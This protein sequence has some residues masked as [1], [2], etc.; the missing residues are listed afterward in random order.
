MIYILDAYNVIHKIPSLDAALDKDLRTARAALIEL[1]G[2]WALSRGEVFKI[3]LVFDG[4]SEFR[5]LPQ[6]SPPK[7]QLVFSETGEDAD[8]R[9][10]DIL[11]ELGEKTTKCVV[12]DDNFVRNQARAYKTQVISVSEFNQWIHK[13]GKNKINPASSS[14]SSK[15]FSLSRKA[16]DEITQAYKKHLGL[17]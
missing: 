2:R 14:S 5:D 11:E 3:I 16:A 6:S 1:C 7:V 13:T 12:S 4:K 10:G 8:E 9:I 15:N 17:D